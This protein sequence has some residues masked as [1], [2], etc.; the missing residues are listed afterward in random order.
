MTFEVKDAALNMGSSVGL[1]GLSFIV[2]SRQII[3]V[4]VPRGM[5]V[6]FVHVLL[7]LRPLD[8]GVVSIDGEPL[9]EVSASP[10]RRGLMGYVPRQ[11]VMPDGRERQFRKGELRRMLME[12]VAT[13]RK[14]VVVVDGLNDNDEREACEQMAYEGAAVVVVNEVD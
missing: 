9:T 6:A 13:S 1:S 14:A 2:K 8:A 5:G 10:L 4:D 3:D 7:G 11:I 12:E